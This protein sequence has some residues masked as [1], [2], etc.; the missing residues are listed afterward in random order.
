LIDLFVIKDDQLVKI[1]SYDEKEGY[2]SG[3]CVFR[4]EYAPPVI[5]KLG[6]CWKLMS[7][8]SGSVGLLY[9]PEEHSSTKESSSDVYSMISAFL[10][11]PAEL[12]MEKTYNGEGVH[13]LMCYHPHLLGAL[14]FSDVLARLLSGSKKMRR[15]VLNCSA[16]WY[17]ISQ[18]APSPTATAYSV[19]PHHNFYTRRIEY[20]PEELITILRTELIH[21]DGP[22]EYYI[23]NHPFYYSLFILAEFDSKAPL[24][25]LKLAK[26]TG[27]DAAYPILRSELKKFI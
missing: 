19:I 3:L 4:E 27:T 7:A 22:E 9:F 12:M 26:E 8:P 17:L 20:I 10:G 14:C 5:M 23:S 2:F 18:E 24:Y 16:L 13:V 1:F 11:N 25:F 6:G 21:K 15:K